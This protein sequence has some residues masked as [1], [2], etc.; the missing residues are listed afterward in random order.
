MI[1]PSEGGSIER[2]VHSHALRLVHAQSWGVRGFQVYVGLAHSCCAGGLTTPVRG[3][4]TGFQALS[5]AA[6]RRAR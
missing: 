6:M 1:Q 4:N 2:T 3:R 5:D